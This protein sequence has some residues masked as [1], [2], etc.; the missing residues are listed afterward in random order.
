MHEIVGEMQENMPDMTILKRLLES[1]LKIIW[2][3]DKQ[4]VNYMKQEREKEIKEEKEY[5][6]EIK[7]KK[8]DQDD[9]K[10]QQ[11]SNKEEVMKDINEDNMR[12]KQ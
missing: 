12:M 1:I 9:I 7:D 8:E 11:I 6:E 2:T 3:I 10:N 4:M 5:K